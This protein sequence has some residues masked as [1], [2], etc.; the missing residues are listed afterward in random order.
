MNQQVATSAEASNPSDEEFRTMLGAML[1]QL[2]AF[3]RGLCR[4]GDFADDLVQETMLK[5]WAARKSFIVN[6]NFRAWTCAILRNHY[7]STMRRKRFVGEWNDA[8]AE[9]VLVAPAAQEKVV[10]VND[11]MRA[12]QELPVDQ[13]EALVLVAAGG[14]SYEEAAEIAAVAI[15][16]IKSRVSRARTAL[17]RL[18]SSGRLATARGTISGQSA[19]VINIMEYL[20]K[21][22]GRRASPTADS[23][24]ARARAAA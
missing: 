23:R 22:Q 3:A 10:E 20:E 9:R 13:R 18:L 21:L 2:R 1:P 16:T 17:E 5:A 12:L 19:S 14:L 24:E 8:T 15:G 4:D 7:L 6:T 11:L